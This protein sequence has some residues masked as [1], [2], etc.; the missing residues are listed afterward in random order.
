MVVKRIMLD[1]FFFHL[2]SEDAVFAELEVK[3]SSGKEKLC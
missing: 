1:N 2:L 3:E